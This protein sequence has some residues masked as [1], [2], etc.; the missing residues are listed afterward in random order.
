MINLLLGRQSSD[1]IDGIK[2]GLVERSSHFILEAPKRLP[3]LPICGVND[4]HMPAL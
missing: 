4:A 2:A 1:R 3:K